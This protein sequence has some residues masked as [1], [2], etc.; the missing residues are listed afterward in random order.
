MRGFSIAARLLPAIVLNI[1]DS[2][3]ARVFTLIHELAHVILQ[4]EGVCELYEDLG[5]VEVFCNA[6]AAS[7]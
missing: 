6:V 1:K 3:Y 5:C 7:F 2:P 4:E